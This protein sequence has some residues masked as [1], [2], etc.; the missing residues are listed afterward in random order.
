MFTYFFE[1]YVAVR[2]NIIVNDYLLGSMYVCLILF[3]LDQ[4]GIRDH[5]IGHCRTFIYLLCRRLG[6]GVAMM[7]GLLDIPQLG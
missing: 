5:I 4:M 7:S 3:N 2:D 1:D 6:Q